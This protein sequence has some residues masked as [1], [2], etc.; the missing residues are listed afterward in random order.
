MN[1][2][3]S[4]MYALSAGTLLALAAWGLYRIFTILKHKTFLDRKDFS[5]LK[6]NPGEIGTSIDLLIKTIKPPFVFEAAV[7]H[8]GKEVTYYLIV[9]KHK[10]KTLMSVKG[11]N[12]AKDYHLFHSGGE[13]LGAYF[14]DGNMW[15][16]VSLEKINFSKVNEIGEGAVAQLVLNKKKRGKAAVNFRIVASAPSVFQAREIMNDLKGCFGEYNS[17]DSSGEEFVHMLNAREFEPGEEMLW[18]IATS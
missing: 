3:D 14:K 17:V 4:P 2:L 7:Q 1:L 10:A 6:I 16:Q 15:P 11:F 9:S 8:L 18:G 13:H 12:E 5:V